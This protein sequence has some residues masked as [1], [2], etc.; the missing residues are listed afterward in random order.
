VWSVLTF[1][2]TSTSLLLR[3][4]LHSLPLSAYFNLFLNKRIN[5]RHSRNLCGPGVGRGAKTPPIFESIQCDGALILFKC[6]LG[7]EIINCRKLNLEACLDVD[8]MLRLTK[9]AIG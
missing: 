9:K 8:F 6:F 4:V 2:S 3:I 5:G 7:P 1:P